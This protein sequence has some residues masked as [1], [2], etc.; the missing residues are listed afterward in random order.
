[1]QPLLSGLEPAKTL[2]V[3]DLTSHAAPSGRKDYTGN[4]DKCVPGP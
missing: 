1:M 2:P 3:Y 4:A